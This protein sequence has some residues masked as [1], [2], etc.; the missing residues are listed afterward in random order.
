METLNIILR[1]YTCVN[2]WFLS[3]HYIFP[4]RGWKLWSRNVYLR[5]KYKVDITSSPQGDGNPCHTAMW[6]SWTL[7]L[8][9]PR[10]GMETF[11]IKPS[12]YLTYILRELTLHL[13]RKG[14]ETVWNSLDFKLTKSCWHYIFPARGW[15][16]P[17]SP[18]HSQHFLHY[19]SWHYIFPARGWK[20]VK[21]RCV[22]LSV[23]LT[24]HLPR[25]GMETLQITPVSHCQGS[26]DITSS[27]QGDGNHLTRRCWVPVAHHCWH[28]IFPARGWKLLL[29]QWYD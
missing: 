12:Y 1:W 19:R 24:L 14:M 8:H 26:V 11:C 29:L 28:Y 18:T 16:L 20:L 2:L 21:F 7:T 17:I 9:L 23:V 4:A 25:K 15:K 27:P 10:K 22:L 5:R 3:W 6:A 13:P